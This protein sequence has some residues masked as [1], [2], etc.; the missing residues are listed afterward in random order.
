[1]REGPTDDGP[2][3]RDVPDDVV[4]EWATSGGGGPSHAPTTDLIVRA[5]G[6]VTVGDRFGGGRAVEATIPPER[7]QELLR[8]IVDRHRFFAID[9]AA[10]ARDLDAARAR[11]AEP[12]AGGGAEAISV[13]LGPPYL[14]AAGTRI[15]VAADGRR[16]EVAVDGLAAAAREYPEVAALTDLR[17]IE[18]L[19]LGLAERVATGQPP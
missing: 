19:L 2:P 4:L 3:G 15:A 8:A 13:P 9:S 1:M 7:L 12:Q 18:L 11:R 14:D 17:A 16:H 10:V 5:N 6:D